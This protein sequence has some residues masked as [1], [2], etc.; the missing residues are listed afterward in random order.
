M[1]KWEIYAYAVRDMMAKAGKLK[2]STK[3]GQDH[4]NYTLFMT[5]KRNEVTFEGKTF[6][7]PHR[8]EEMRTDKKQ[9]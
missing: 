1:E 7:W 3:T 6:Y 2:K 5:G 8:E 4:V 9:D